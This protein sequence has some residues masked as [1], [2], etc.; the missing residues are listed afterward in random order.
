VSALS[1]SRNLMGTAPLLSV[2]VPARNATG[3]L[4]ESLPALATSDL[5]R[6]SW[7][8]IVVDDAS[9]DGTA[10]LAAAHADRVVRLP[11]PARGP[12]YARNR[13][14]EA[15]R[16]DIL[17]FVDADV[18]VHETTL[19]RLLRTL[20]AAPDA[21]AV[22]GAYDTTPRAAGLVSQYRNLLHHYVHALHAGDADTFWTGCGAIRR[23]PFFEAGGFDEQRYPRPQIEDIAL[24]YRLRALGRRVMLRP[25]IQAT[26]LKCWTLRGM[27]SS[28][29]LDRGVPWMHLLLG[30]EAPG[31]GSL[32]VRLKE[33]LLTAFAGAALLSILAAPIG[34]SNLLV[35]AAIFVLLV[36]AGNLPF[37]SWC[38]RLR[39]VGFALR[40][41]P[42]HLLHYTLNALA[43]GMALVQHLAHGRAAPALSGGDRLS[44]TDTITAE[45]PARRH[46]P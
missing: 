5:P 31:T 25:D 36:L 33:R 26:H 2:I 1:R 22:F 17:V 4:A 38:A 13:G 30:R 44:A 24:G 7:E 8:L 43:V 40:I 10:D 37:F 29:L 14:C 45:A 3:V 41:V 35:A 19:G 32:N 21:A 18:C 9:T 27:I 28:D 12:A 46:A 23:K 20:A 16:G 15:A 39:G 6:E 34:G 42:L 11:A